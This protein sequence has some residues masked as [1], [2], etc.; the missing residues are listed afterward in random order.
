V[1]TRALL[2]SL[3]TILLGYGQVPAP[4]GAGQQ[5][6]ISRMKE[7]AASYNVRLQD[8]LATQTMTR[9]TASTG[10]NPRWKVLETQESELS[11]VGHKVN[12]KLLK[13]NGKT[14]NLDKEVKRGYFIFS[15]EFGALQRVFDP[16]A[17][18]EFEWDHV[19]LSEGKR[20]CVFRYRIAKANTNFVFYSD[21]DKTPAAHHGL[22]SADCDTGMVMQFHLETESAT[23]RRAGRDVPLGY[24][25][26]VRY[27]FTAIAGQEFLLPQVAEAI[28]LF[29][30]RLTKAEVKFQQYRKYDSSSTITFG[31]R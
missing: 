25:L 27:A 6:I 13:V 1:Q 7:A 29:N 30:T 22:V 21:G 26:N 5:A 16:K 17:N 31:D 2:F 15:D 9:S 4:D 8:F 12:S 28:S 3:A 11:Y 23:V 14:T 18:P 19:E 24:E 10:A 20:L